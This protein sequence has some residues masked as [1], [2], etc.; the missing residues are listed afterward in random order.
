MPAETVKIDQAGRVALPKTILEASGMGPDVEVVVES[1]D[2]GIL[3]RPKAQLGP[4]TARIASMELP[5]GD[6][7][8]MEH[9]LRLHQL[10][11]EAAERIKRGGG[12]PHDEFW[13]QVA[14]ESDASE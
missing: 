6:W 11:D 8:D 7:E 3:I 1:T 5:V 13:R 2:I 14:E 10:L 12:I 4:I 9:T